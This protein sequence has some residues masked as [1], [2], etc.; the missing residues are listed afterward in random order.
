V[1]HEVAAQA[2][3]VAVERRQRHAG[4]DPPGGGIDERPR[5]GRR[6]SE[7]RAGVRNSRDVSMP[8]TAIGV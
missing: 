5:V 1:T 6:W 2:A 4:L 7:R 3:G 8:G